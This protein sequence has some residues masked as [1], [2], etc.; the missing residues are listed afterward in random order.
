MRQAGHQARRDR[1]PTGHAPCTGRLC[2]CQHLPGT[3]GGQSPSAHFCGDRYIN[4]TSLTFQLLEIP[5]FN[6]KKTH[7][8][9]SV[10]SKIISIIFINRQYDC[11][12][13]NATASICITVSHQQIKYHRVR[14]F[15]STQTHPQ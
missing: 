7:F 12:L 13:H 10:Q 6:W 3:H 11:M 9:T 1:S 14:M 5:Q 4:T 15:S 8:L 2:L